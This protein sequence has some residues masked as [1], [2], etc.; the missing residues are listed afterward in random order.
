M[1]HTTKIVIAV[2]LIFSAASFGGTYS[3]GTGEPNDPYL[4][5]TAEDLNSIG[6]DPND[7]SKHFKLMADIDTNGVEYNI[8]AGGSETWSYQ[9]EP[10]VGS[11]DGDGHVIKNLTINDV[12][13]SYI[14]LFGYIGTGGEIKNLRLENFNLTGYGYVGAVAGENK[15]SI[16]NCFSE[17]NIQIEYKYAGGIVGEN[18]GNISLSSSSSNIYGYA[19]LGGLVGRNNGTI[20]KCD[21]EGIVETNVC[22]GPHCGGLVGLNYHSGTILNSVSNSTVYGGYSDAGGFAG[23]N[24]GVM[25]NCHSNSDVI[26]IEF[27]TGGLVGYNSR[28]EIYNCHSK[29]YVSGKYYIGGLVGLNS[30]GDIIGSYAAGNVCGQEEVGGLTGWNTSGEITNC[31]ATGDVNG[32]QYIGGLS[33]GINSTGS[34]TNCYATGKVIGNENTG[35]LLGYN[36]GIIIESF[37]DVNSS[38]IMTSAG[39]SGRSTAEMQTAATF[40]TAGWDFNTPVWTIDE[41][42]DYPRL[43][44]ET[45]VEP[46]DLVTELSE[47]IDTM[48]LQKCITNNLHV[49]LDTVLR[50][51]ENENKHNDVAA[52]NSLQAFINAVNAQHGKKISEENADY[53]ATATQ[54][55]IDMLSSE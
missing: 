39:G 38:G 9:G 6:L 17:V 36:T 5:A 35:G 48:S 2:V 20:D 30:Y 7:W 4:I 54:Q 55:I 3:G 19:D 34:I 47:N 50:L 53:L 28:G 33:G 40:M 11:F 51:L 31:Y 52:I 42:F 23:T 27:S 18:E 10:F 24:F 14:G 16:N 32:I 1:N 13:Q 29:G 22:F 44:W 26:G 8:I 37:W 12:S 49:K 15:G 21:S 41:G 45:L 43:W 46:V 25:E